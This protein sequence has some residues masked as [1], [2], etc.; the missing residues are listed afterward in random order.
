MKS[1]LVS[2]E[3]AAG[4]ECLD[5]LDDPQQRA[6]TNAATALVDSA[7]PPEPADGQLLTAF[8]ARH[9]KAAFETLVHRHGP[10]VFGVCRRML[11]NAEDA[12]DAF[13]AV[14]LVLVRK[15]ASIRR[16]QALRT[17][18]YHTAVRT[19]LKAR[20]I[21]GRRMVREKAM[22][23]MPE[24]AA[25]PQVASEEDLA[26]LDE[27]LRALPQKY[28]LPV[29]LCELEGRTRKDAAKILQLPEGTVSSR[30]ATARQRLASRL[31]RRGVTV[32]LTGLGA[33]LAPTTASAAMPATLAASTV[34][35]ASL[36]GA[37]H[38]ATSVVSAKVAALTQGV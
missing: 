13:Q 16:P 7:E 34:E 19:S 9:D 29:I 1:S 27:E 38:V 5:M 30:L 24:T 15:A 28:Q 21:R 25:T 2:C 35:A 31:R 14:F 3:S 26:L 12:A 37:G 17:W 32:S 20:T 22:D 11:G 8:L 36:F 6:H 18:L 10:L 4:E 23:T 33:L